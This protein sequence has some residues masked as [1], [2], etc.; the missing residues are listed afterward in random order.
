MPAT[1]LDFWRIASLATLHQRDR[2]AYARIRKC[3]DPAGLSGIILRHVG[4]QSLH[5]QDVG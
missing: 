5:E 1:E 3:A 4:A 2:T